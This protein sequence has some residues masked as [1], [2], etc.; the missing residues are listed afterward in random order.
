MKL[1]IKTQKNQPSLLTIDACP[2]CNCKKLMPDYATGEIY[3]RYCGL[4][5][6]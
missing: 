2:A 4:V 5:I 3:C 1:H 6:Y